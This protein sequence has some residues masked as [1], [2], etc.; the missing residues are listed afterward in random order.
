LDTPTYI[1]LSCQSSRYIKLHERLK[2]CVLFC[3]ENKYISRPPRLF[4]SRI[5]GSCRNRVSLCT[6]EGIYKLHMHVGAIYDS[7]FVYAWFC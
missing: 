1:S 6:D 5:A 2:F 4:P 7:N 3:D